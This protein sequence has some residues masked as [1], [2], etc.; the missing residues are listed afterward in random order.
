[1]KH[2]PSIIFLKTESYLF[3]SKHLKAKHPLRC[4]LVVRC[5]DAFINSST[6]LPPLVQEIIHCRTPFEELL[7]YN[8]PQ[9]IQDMV[10]AGDIQGALKGL[11]ISPSHPMTFAGGVAEFY[12]KEIQKLNQKLEQKNRETPLDTVAIAELVNKI[13]TSE[14]EITRVTTKL[15]QTSKEACTICFEPPSNPMVIPCCYNLFCGSCI[16]QWMMKT[17]ACPLC[18]QTVLPRFLVNITTDES[19]EKPHTSHILPSKKNALLKIL[20]ENPDGRF[21]VFSR[22]DNPLV[23]IH[24]TISHDFPSQTLQGNKDI[25]AKQITDFETGITRILLV[26]SHTSIAGMNLPSAT[27]VILLHKMGMEDE[28]SILGRSYR[29]GRVT[30]LHY[31]K[32]LNEGE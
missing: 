9:N 20:Q 10:H 18:R 14:G 29:I 19:V 32:L 12:K 15:E 2:H 17:S 1:M 21:L 23:D 31:V 3:F 13:R 6:Q 4:H 5:A 26:N 25:I 16:L 28:Q 30:P 27:H 8:M 7:N 22:F 11:G 24:E